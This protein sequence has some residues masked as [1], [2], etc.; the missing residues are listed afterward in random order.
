MFWTKQE[1]ACFQK[2]LLKVGIPKNEHLFW[3][4]NCPIIMIWELSLLPV[5]EH[6]N[7]LYSL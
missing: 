2:E 3:K 4:L 6:S 7:R 1:F 5:A